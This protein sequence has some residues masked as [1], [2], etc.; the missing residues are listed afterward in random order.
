MHCTGYVVIKLISY[1]Y[2]HAAECMYT[3][4]II[5]ELHALTSYMGMHAGK[6]FHIAIGICIL[7][8]VKLK[9][10]SVL[11]LYCNNGNA[12]RWSMRTS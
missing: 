3:L 9:F 7:F 2:I 12:L 5:T 4:Y 1:L 6:L 8:I 10:S 11:I